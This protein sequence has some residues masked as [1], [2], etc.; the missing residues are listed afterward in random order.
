MVIHKI[1]CGKNITIGETMTEIFVRTVKPVGNTGHVI[2]PKRHIGKRVTVIVHE[3]D[4]KERKTEKQ[5][6]RW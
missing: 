5:N 1:P 4:E 2:V 6:F 3:E